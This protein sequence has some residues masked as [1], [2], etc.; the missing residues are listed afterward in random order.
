MNDNDVTII[1]AT[2]GDSSWRSV[3]M[4]AAASASNQTVPAKNVIRLQEDTLPNARNF[5][6]KMAESEWLIFLDAD[7]ELDDS[8]VEAMLAGEGDIRRP[9]TLGVVNGVEDDEPVM[10]PQ[11]DM[12]VSNCIVIGAMCR[13]D[14]FLDVG[15][16][17]DYPCLEDWALWRD[18][19]ANGATVGEVPDAIYR[20]HVNPD[21]RNTNVDLH[22][23]VYR[24]IRK[25]RI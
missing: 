14:Q 21:S 13:R 11:T 5:G 1:I 3:A 9:A 19:I 18:L 25:T 15:G 6:A 20:V 16:F 2:F 22:S 17:R 23:K 4:R 24:Q 12:N 10:I 7:D 8:Y